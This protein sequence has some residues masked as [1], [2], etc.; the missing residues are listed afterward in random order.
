MNPNNNITLNEMINK[1]SIN[2]KKS[3]YIY[4]KISYSKNAKR[5]YED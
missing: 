1:T 3:Y 5:K 2:H 4:Y